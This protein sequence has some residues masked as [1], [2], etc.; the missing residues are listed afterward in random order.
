[1]GDA[2][3]TVSPHALDDGAGD[4]PHAV[5]QHQHLSGQDHGQE[6]GRVVVREGG[7]RMS[8]Q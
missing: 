7:G 2:D 5:V 3:R 1:M 6:G 4:H 8:L